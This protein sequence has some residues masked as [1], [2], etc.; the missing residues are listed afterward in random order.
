[1]RPL[2]RSSLT[3]AQGYRAWGLVQDIFGHQRLPFD[4]LFS[5]GGPPTASAASP[6]TRGAHAHARRRPLGRRAAV[7]I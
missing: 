6:S 1:M 4:D 2:G 3:W 7:V 5:A